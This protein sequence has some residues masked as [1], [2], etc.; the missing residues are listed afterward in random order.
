MCS[1]QRTGELQGHDGDA[2]GE[3]QNNG[4]GD[5]LCERLDCFLNDLRHLSS[6]LV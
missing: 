1:I 6:L 2:V 5:G 3:P 4:V